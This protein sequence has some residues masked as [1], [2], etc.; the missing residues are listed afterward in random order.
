[1]NR[2]LKFDELRPNSRLQGHSKST[3][4]SIAN[5][6]EAERGLGITKL[7]PSPIANVFLEGDRFWTRGIS[8]CTDQVAGNEPQG[9]KT[10]RRDAVFNPGGPLS[11]GSVIGVTVPYQ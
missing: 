9:S 11:G 7:F 1:M 3:L 6:V 10:A 5:E 2:R 4:T 8:Y